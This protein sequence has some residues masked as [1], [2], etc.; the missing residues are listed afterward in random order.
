MKIAQLHKNS[1][2]C[3]TLLSCLQILPQVPGMQIVPRGN[4]L[5]V[6]AVF[7][8]L[9]CL[10][11]LYLCQILTKLVKTFSYVIT[12]LFLIFTILQNILFLWRIGLILLKDPFSTKTA[13]SVFI[14]HFCT[15]LHDLFFDRFTE[16]ILIFLLLQNSLFQEGQPYFF[17]ERCCTPYLLA[18]MCGNY[19]KTTP[20]ECSSPQ[21]PHVQLFSTC[22]FLLELLQSRLFSCFEA[23][24]QYL[25]YR[26]FFKET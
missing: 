9:K 21:L 5:L 11:S 24:K 22:S 19:F 10:Y 2:E 17:R 18:A 25:I 7:T 16:L 14:G 6:L 4:S 23:F 13:K 8:I 20:H 3:G 15:K 26:I 1:H 12:G